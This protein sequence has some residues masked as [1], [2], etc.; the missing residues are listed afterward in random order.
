MARNPFVDFSPAALDEAAG[1]FQA[2]ADRTRLQQAEDD[3]TN[4]CHTIGL[5][6][7]LRFDIRS[8]R[9]VRKVQHA[10]VMRE[11]ARKKRSDRV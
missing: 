2:A 6:F 11:W 9:K 1:V 4:A 5:A 3:H 8:L 7:Q 10:N